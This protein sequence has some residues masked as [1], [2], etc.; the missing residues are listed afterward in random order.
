MEKRRGKWRLQKSGLQDMAERYRFE[1]YEA[2]TSWQ[3]SILAAAECFCE[4]RKGG[5]TSADRSGQAKRIS[6]PPL[7]IG[8]CSKARACAT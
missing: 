8:C 5:F 1:T 2:K 4:E 7:R 3:K 6:A